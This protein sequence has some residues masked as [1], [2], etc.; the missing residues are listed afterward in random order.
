[1]GTEAKKSLAD[2]GVCG[3]QGYFGA[4][5]GLGV[6]ICSG[7][8]PTGKYSLAAATVCIN[9]AAVSRRRRAMPFARLH[10]ALVSALVRRGGMELLLPWLWRPARLCAQLD[11]GAPR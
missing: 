4:V 6:S 3:A 11:S 8:C 10:V 7:A 2:R 5:V 1:V 9:C